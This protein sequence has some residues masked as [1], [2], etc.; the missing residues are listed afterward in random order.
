[1]IVWRLSHRSTDPAADERVDAAPFDYCLHFLAIAHYV[2][3]ASVT[4][5]LG[6]SRSRTSSPIGLAI[7]ASRWLSCHPSRGPNVALPR[8][9]ISRFCGR[10]C[11]APA[12]YLLL[13]GGARGLAANSLFGW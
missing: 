5:L 2:G 10:C 3:Y 13:R 12:L 8:P 1:M 6:I 4:K 9:G 7:T 11:E